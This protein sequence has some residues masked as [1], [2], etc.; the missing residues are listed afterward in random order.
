MRMDRILNK[1]LN[2]KIRY[3]DN[4]ALYGFLGVKDEED[5]GNSRLFPGKPQGCCENTGQKLTISAP[6]MEEMD[7]STQDTHRTN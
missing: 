5:F 3:L 2:S 4:T 6:S 1:I 7:N